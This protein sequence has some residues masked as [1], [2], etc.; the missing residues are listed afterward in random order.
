[1]SHFDQHS[2]TVYSAVSQCCWSYR[3]KYCSMCT[4]WWWWWSQ[5][6]T[7]TSS[8]EFT[9]TAGVVHS[10]PRLNQWAAHF[11]ECLI[12]DSHAS[13][14][15]GIHR[16]MARLFRKHP[17]DVHLKHGKKR[18]TRVEFFCWCHIKSSVVCETINLWCGKVFS[19]SLF[20]LEIYTDWFL[21]TED[22]TPFVQKWMT[23][24]N[25]NSNR[26]WRGGQLALLSQ[27]VGD[28]LC[29]QRTVHEFISPVVITLRILYSV[30]YL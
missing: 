18:C 4:W 11:S 3:P 6:C 17:V 27:L 5:Q 7:V 15:V 24:V 19:W 28:V 16:T 25:F 26:L 13:Q 2:H 23:W 30:Q 21:S 10:F 9:E 22:F 29:M 20:V 8:S 12:Y 14:T 1:M